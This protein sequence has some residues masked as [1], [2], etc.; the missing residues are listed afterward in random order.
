MPPCTVRPAGL[1]VWTVPAGQSP[2]TW[3]FETLT[4]NPARR[5]VSR[6]AS[7]VWHFTFGMPTLLPYAIWRLGGE[8]PRN[9]EVIRS[10]L[11]EDPFESQRMVNQVLPEH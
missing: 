5:R 7:T 1:V 3:L 2:L 6:A 10:R 8:D 4:L 9:W 11:L